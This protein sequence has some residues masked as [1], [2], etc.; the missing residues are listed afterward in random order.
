MRC[1]LGL[2]ANAI[3]SALAGFGVA[4]V[5]ATFGYAPAFYIAAG[6]IGGCLAGVAVCLAAD[7]ADDTDAAAGLPKVVGLVG[8]LA[9][10]AAALLGNLSPPEVKTAAVIF[11]FV[12]LGTQALGLAMALAKRRAGNASKRLPRPDRQKPRG[13]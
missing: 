2:A 11:W 12:G 13:A 3:L 4:E 7:A 5:A 1:F 10:C 9:V 6:L 8:T